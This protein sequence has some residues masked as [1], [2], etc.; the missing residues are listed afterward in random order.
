MSDLALE[1]TQ[2]ISLCEA[3]DRLLAT[4]VVLVGEAT[5]SLAQIDLIYVGVQLVVSSIQTTRETPDEPDDGRD[6]RNGSTAIGKNEYELPNRC[7]NRVPPNGSPHSFSNTNE[8]WSPA[9]GTQP[10]AHPRVGSKETQGLAKL[11]LTLMKLLHEL[12]ERQALRRVESGSLSLAETERLG[13][14]LMRQAQEI[15]RLRQEFGLQTGDLNLDLG[16][17]GKLL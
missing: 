14:T 15:E 4:G 10:R 5:I 6:A 17:L 16:P 12:L 13:M 8:R 2:R 1:R 9:N 11:V 7:V 3:L